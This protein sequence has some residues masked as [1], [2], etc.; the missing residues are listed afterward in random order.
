MMARRDCS[1]AVAALRDLFGAR[2]LT[3]AAVCVSHGRDESFHRSHPPDAV[4]KPR[5]KFEVQQIV[6][7]CAAHAAPIIPRGA[8]TSLEGNIAALAGGICIDSA[9]MNQILAVNSE[10]FDV[11]VQP[12]VTRRQLDQHLK[13][14][15][16]FFPVDPGADA[17]LGG[18]AATRAS[19]TTTVRYGAMRENVINIEAV[20][21]DGALI[22]SA[23][24]ARKS[25]AGYDLT[26][27]LV[28]SEGSLAVFTELTL[29]LYPVPEAI[30]AAVC[31]FDSIKGAVDTVI[32]MLQYGVPVARL[33]LLD[34]LTLKSVNLYSKT[35]FSEAPT[36]FLE[37]HGSD[38]GVAEQAKTTQQLAAENGGSEFEW[39]KNTE[40]RRRMWRA[41]HDVAYAG[42]LLH[43]RGQIWATDVCVPI[44]K[45]AE[46][47]AQTG[48]DIEEF[49][50]LA[51]LVGHVG[52]GN[53]HLL[54]LVDHDDADEVARAQALHERM[55]M[56][57]L[58]MEGTCTGE[59]G[60][61]YGKIE[62]LKHEHGAALTPMR[63]I[64]KALDPDNIFNPGKIFD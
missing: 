33:E 57:A 59:H 10:D 2:L 17:S 40:Q 19:G 52:D 38:G 48:R 64:K 63:M 29:R 54:L 50:L 3:S 18:M 21:A 35:S 41:R 46:C 31:V 23:R 62:F 9:E 4:I 6:Q 15:G 53:F 11:A 1:R 36:L 45:L 13:D 58:D 61:G 44:S 24:R 16:L 49:K 26:R 60:I 42:K 30:A 51:P 12:G 39:S 7:V 25:A 56:R 37:F 34:A 8:G 22:R 43:P 14:S 32:Q 5:D 27:L 47:I 28:G 20:L 55:V